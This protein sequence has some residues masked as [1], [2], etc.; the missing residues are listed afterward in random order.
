MTQVSP[1]RRPIDTT[2]WCALTVNYCLVASGLPGDD[3]H[4][5]LDFARYGNC[6]SGATLGAIAIK[7]RDGGGCAFVRRR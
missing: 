6:L 1:Q 2:P 7:K 3:S 4:W 5:A